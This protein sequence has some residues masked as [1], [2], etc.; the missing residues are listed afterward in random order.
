MTC[1]DLGVSFLFRLA[2]KDHSGGPIV[3]IY[4]MFAQRL[5][6]YNDAQV[7]HLSVSFTGLYTAVHYKTGYPYGD[8]H[9]MILLF[10]Q[11]MVSVKV[12][13]TI[14]AAVLP[15]SRGHKCNF[16]RNSKMHSSIF[17]QKQSYNYITRLQ[18]TE[19]FRNY[20]ELVLNYDWSR[21]LSRLLYFYFFLDIFRNRKFSKNSLQLLGKFYDEFNQNMSQKYKIEP[22]NKF[23]MSFNLRLPPEC[24]KRR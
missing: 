19:R 20:D 11:K 7:L 12:T 4:H 15:K 14:K 17:F 24:L 18:N 16:M 9:R 22:I 10:G 21:N 6:K 8:L 5:W 2:P 3:R 13:K 1:N 23:A